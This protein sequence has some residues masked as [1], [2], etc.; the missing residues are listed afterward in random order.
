REFRFQT[1][2]G[3]VLWMTVAG[4]PMY[5]AAQQ[6]TGVLVMC[7]DITERRKAQAELDRER[8]RLQLA[9]DAAN[10][11]TWERD[12]A[13]GSVTWSHQLDS[14]SGVG[15]VHPDD[16]GVVGAAIKESLETNVPFQIEYRSVQPDATL[17]WILSV[18][19]A[20]RDAQGQP[21]SLM[22]IAIDTTSR[23]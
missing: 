6:V 2:S 1:K 18:G 3:G 5:D 20:I 7:T 23:R 14:T 13:S 11:G 16:H 19:R 8:E 4:S 15:I 22:G 12:I 9:L 21:S 17:R 10:M